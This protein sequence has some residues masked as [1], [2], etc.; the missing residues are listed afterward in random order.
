MAFA[1]SL[2]SAAALSFP[3][4]FDREHPLVARHELPAVRAHGRLHLLD[5]LLFRVGRGDIF[6]EGEDGLF[7]VLRAGLAVLVPI[8][9]VVG[10][11]LH[12]ARPRRLERLWVLPES[13]SEHGPDDLDAIRFAAGS[14]EVLHVRLGDL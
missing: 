11:S 10:R 5:S 7:Y 14:S 3:K 6:G 13:P 12:L 9:L 1:A 2:L 4:S 8:V